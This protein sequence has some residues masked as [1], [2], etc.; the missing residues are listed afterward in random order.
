MVRGTLGAGDNF[1]M[2]GGYTGAKCFVEA[3]KIAD[4]SPLSSSVGAFA[5]PLWIKTATATSTSAMS[6]VDSIYMW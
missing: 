5:C 1:F 2:G 3:T 6:P 4:P